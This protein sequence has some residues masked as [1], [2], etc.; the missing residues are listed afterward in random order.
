MRI[1][2]WRGLRIGVFSSTSPS[3]VA[4]NINFHG[5]QVVSPDLPQ[6]HALPAADSSTPR[7][8]W[9]MVDVVDCPE[10]ELTL[11]ACTAIIQTPFVREFVNEA[12]EVIY[13]AIAGG[14]FTPRLGYETRKTADAAGIP[15]PD[16]PRQLTP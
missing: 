16:D 2:T 8:W 1:E 4:P 6:V 13:R 12:R 7:T 3:W 11:P 15:L 10:L 9:A 14:G 5:L